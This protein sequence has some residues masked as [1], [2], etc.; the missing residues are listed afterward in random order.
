[1]AV[2]TFARPRL[3]LSR[4]I[5]FDR[6]RWNGDMIASPVVRMLAPE[7][8]MVPVC[9]ETEIG[10]GVPRD[11]V[12]LVRAGGDDRLV[13]PA[14]GRDI[15]AAMGAF[16]IRFLDA[17]G[18][19]D[20]IILKNRSPSCGTGNVRIYAGTASPVVAAKGPGIFARAVLD[21][22]PGLP[23]EDEGRL[24][25]FRILDHFL[26]AVFT[27][28][29]F[30]E[31]KEAGGGIRRLIRFH[32]ENKLLLS[33]HNRSLARAMGRIAG[34]GEQ[35]GM[36]PAYEALLL[37]AL[38][39]PP[40]PGAVIDVLLHAAGHFSG[41]VTAAEKALLLDALGRYRRG[42]ADA[43]AAKSIVRA[44]IVRFEDGYLDRQTFFA[45]YP[46]TLF[47]RDAEIPGHGRDLW[48]ERPQANP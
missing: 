2:R 7:A 37:Q 15:T 48:A 28:A 21:R 45:P 11:P 26:T 36:I 39:R 27:I 34:G 9:P 33:A 4:C 17:A 29:D 43:C 19:L 47:A 30:R 44:W 3:L 32:A 14:T 38:A 6:C 40:R 31:L 20:G 18:S 13:Q 16:A 1:M 12:R 23:L 35:E 5:E 22:Y 24:R 8:D 46:D 25:N 42:Q 41:R 10:L